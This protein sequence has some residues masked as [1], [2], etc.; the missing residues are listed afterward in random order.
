[1]MALTS[2]SALI[3]ALLAM[4]LM[5]LL[6]AWALKRWRAP[7]VRVLML[8]AMRDALPDALPDASDGSDGSDGSLVTLSRQPR[9]SA[10]ED[11]LR[12]AR[13]DRWLRLSVERREQHLFLRATIPLGLG[14]QGLKAAALYSREPGHELRCVLEWGGLLLPQA[15]LALA[16]SLGVE[17]VEALMPGHW[18][19]HSRPLSPMFIYI[20]D[21]LLIVGAQVD[22][23]PLARQGALEPQDVHALRRWLDQLAR[24]AQ[25]FD[26][27]SPLGVEDWSASLLSDP[28]VDAATRAEV[29]AQISVSG[30]WT[31]R[32][33]DAL[34][35]LVPVA[36]ME[37]AWLA[38]EKLTALGQPWPRLPDEAHLALLVYAAGCVAWRDR[39]RDP[40]LWSLAQRVS[41]LQEDMV[42]ARLRDSAAA[43]LLVV[44]ARCGERDQAFIERALDACFERHG[45]ALTL[46]AVST[47]VASPWRRALLERLR[48]AR[49]SA[50]AIERLSVILADGRFELQDMEA[51][52]ALL[53]VVLV[54]SDRERAG[55]LMESIERACATPQVLAALSRL[56][57]ALPEVHA[58]HSPLA[59]SLRRLARVGPLGGGALTLADQ[60]GGQLTLSGEGG[61]LSL[62]DDPLKDEPSHDP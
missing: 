17:R 28:E 29:I 13:G 27:L 34:R 61:A 48:R 22:H 33:L 42:L 3:M 35:A 57:A 50:L 25:R 40:T 4:A 16:W 15:Q 59:S 39:A 23:E 11:A 2:I 47:M 56:L 32:R 45:D 37:C 12:V 52:S 62:Q 49:W 26:A 20:Q 58:A 53:P 8:H 41:A 31:A 60:G 30:H 14:S 46:E 54:A 24:S 7:D 21:G 43:D 36:R 51:L 5:G 44:A 38:L 18:S 6:I 10:P 55:A 9:A 1:M 19:A